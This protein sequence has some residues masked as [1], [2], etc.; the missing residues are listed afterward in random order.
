MGGRRWGD[1]RIREGE[2]E[3]ID[4]LVGLGGGGVSILMMGSWG[5]EGND[6][7]RVEGYMRGETCINREY[8]HLESRQS[9]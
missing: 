2:D 3:I 9:L 1:L 8:R 5:G 7:L 4:G 6:G